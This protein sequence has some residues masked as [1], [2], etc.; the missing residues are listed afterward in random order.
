MFY[1]TFF[2]I[3]FHFPVINTVFNYRTLNY[4][5]CIIRDN[6]QHLKQYLSLMGFISVFSRFRLFSPRKQLIC[7]SNHIQHLQQ[8]G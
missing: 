2:V 5:E 7:D 8:I 3:I 1:V 6:L 4:R